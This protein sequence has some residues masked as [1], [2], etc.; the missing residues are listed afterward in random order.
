MRKEVLAQTHLDRQGFET[1]LPRIAATRR[2]A[3]KTEHVRAAMFPRYLF[4]RLNPERDKWRSVNGT[5]GMA[6]LLTANDAPCPIPIGFVESLK[7]RVGEDGLIALTPSFAL[8]DKVR[9]A[10]GPFAD[11]LGEIVRLDTPRR[12]E[13]LLEM[14]NREIRVKVSP[15]LLET[16][17]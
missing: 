12:V 10:S 7:R 2:H 13:I 11:R 17:A 5:I 3:R 15:D 6:Y 1:F 4:V 16:A 8:G 14:L 9:I